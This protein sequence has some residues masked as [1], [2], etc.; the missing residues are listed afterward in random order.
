MLGSLL[1]TKTVRSSRV[2]LVAAFGMLAVLF[3]EIALANSDAV[4]WYDTLV[5]IRDSF[6]G[7]VARA[8]II[9]AL[10]VTGLTLAFGELNGLTAIAFRLLFGMTLALLSVQFIGMFGFSEAEC[11]A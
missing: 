5:L 2:L 1:Q 4:P 6:C 3:P 9:I 7:P 8:G 11:G 10:V